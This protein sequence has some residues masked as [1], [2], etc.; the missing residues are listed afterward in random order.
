MLII[1][2]LQRS[3]HGCSSVTDRSPLKILSKIDSST[4]SDGNN[5]YKI[6]TPDSDDDLSCPRDK[7]SQ[8]YHMLKM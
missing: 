4:K 8:V 3:Q 6:Q 1:E 5:K 2:R 7:L